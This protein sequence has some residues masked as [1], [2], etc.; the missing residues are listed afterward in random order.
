[1]IELC[2]D[3]KKFLSICDKLEEVKNPKLTQQILYD[4]MVASLYSKEA[5]TYVSHEDENM[6]GCIVLWFTKDILGESTLGMVF[7][8]ID[9]HY[10][11]LGK[12]FIRIACDK[13][14]ELGAKKI[15]FTT[16]RKEEIINRRLGKFGFKKACS[17]FEKRIEDVI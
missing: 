7:T 13:A 14:R 6:N 5:Y 12:E 2:V 1:M 3:N 10:P 11:N 8:W 9:A 17:V 4:Y 16:N 15:S